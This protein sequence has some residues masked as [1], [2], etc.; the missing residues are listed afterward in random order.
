MKTLHTKQVQS[1]LRQF[2]FIPSTRG[3]GTSM[4]VWIDGA[5]RSC[6]MSYSGTDFD[7]SQLYRLA[8]ELEGKGICLRRDFMNAAQG[9]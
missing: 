3:N 5:G 4:K 2:G 8:Q 1:T 9:R 6:R 7:I